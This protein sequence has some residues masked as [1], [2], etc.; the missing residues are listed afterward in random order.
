MSDLT[1]TNAKPLAKTASDECSQE[2][3]RRLTDKGV[4]FFQA[5]DELAASPTMR[6]E[7][8][9]VNAQLQRHAAPCGPKAVVNLLVPLVTLYGVSD[10]SEGEWKAFW[11]FYVE[12]LRELPYAALKAGVEEYVSDAKSEFFP[13][14]GPLK[15]ICLRHAAPLITATSRA[16][17]ALETDPV[18]ASRRI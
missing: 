14:P 4:G 17:K 6:R 16:R 3:W 13:K 2:L 10:K 18:A 1:T 11:G 9:L 15:A 12:A 5:A 7:L 8:E